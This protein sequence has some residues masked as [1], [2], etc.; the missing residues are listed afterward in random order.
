MAKSAPREG[1]KIKPEKKKRE[2]IKPEKNNDK[3]S[4][5]LSFMDI[6]PVFDEF[7]PYLPF[8]LSILTFLHNFMQN[9]EKFSALRTVCSF[10]RAKFVRDGKIF[11]GFVPFS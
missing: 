3:L 4:T 9:S 10:L 6:F 8:Q 1:G 2:K 5:V 7:L 11:S